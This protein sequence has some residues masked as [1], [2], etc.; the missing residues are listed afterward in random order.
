MHILFKWYGLAYRLCKNIHTEYVITSLS[1][2]A[3]FR[4]FIDSYDTQ[5][6]TKITHKH[7]ALMIS[8]NQKNLD[9]RVD[10]T[11]K[12][13]NSKTYGWYGSHVHVNIG[14]YCKPLKKITYTKLNS[15]N[16]FFVITHHDTNGHRIVCTILN[17]GIG[18]RFS[19]GVHFINLLYFTGY[20]ITYPCWNFT[21][22]DK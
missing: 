10:L 7:R 22:M 20:V 3:L 4:R 12:F 14:T 9:S 19:P 5:Y 1:I 2:Q 11:D 18:L 16:I 6:Y 21:S 8:S 15:I 13:T 17:Q